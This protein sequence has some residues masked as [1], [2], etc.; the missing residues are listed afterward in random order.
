MDHL[1]KNMH[2][3]AG[4]TP[5]MTLDT[6]HYVADLVAELQVLALQSDLTTLASILALA[7]SELASQIAAR[8]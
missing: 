1:N 7:Q 6:L 3:V 5:P 2:F 4:P 8:Q